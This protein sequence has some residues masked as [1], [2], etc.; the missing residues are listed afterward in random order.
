M[1]NSDLFNLQSPAEAVVNVISN[2]F[3]KLT[4]PANKCDCTR[5]SRFAKNGEELASKISSRSA[6]PLKMFWT[7]VVKTPVV[8]NLY[9]EMTGAPV[10]WE[11]PHK[12]LDRTLEHTPPRLSLGQWQVHLGLHWLCQTWGKLVASSH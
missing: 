1:H 10:L 4:Y 2:S 9:E 7:T 12:L 3:F 11:I 6:N 8:D 5:Y